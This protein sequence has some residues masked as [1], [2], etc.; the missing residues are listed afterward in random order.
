MLACR[1]RA[2]ID[3]RYSPSVD[4]VLALAPPVLRHRMAVSFAGRAEG[5]TVGAG[6]RP[7]FGAA[8]V[9]TGGPR[10][11]AALL[12][13]RRAPHRRRRCAAAPKQAAAALPPLLVAAERVAA[14]VAQGVHGR[15]RVGPGRD[16][17]AVPPISAGRRGQPH[18]LARERQVAAPLCPR[19]RMGGG[20]ERVAVARRLGLDGLQL[21]RIYCRRR[22]ADQARP[23]R[24]AAGRAGEPAG[25]RRRARDAA[26]QRHGAGER[27]GRLVAG[28][29]A[30]RPRADGGRRACPPSSRCRAP[31]SSC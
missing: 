5:V 27:P 2:L 14:T 22:L 15:R 30:A 21:G 25:A 19:D 4:D 20:A 16:L 13:R 1:A 24:I 3:G 8:P 9:N 11:L 23:R 17:L 12:A 31:A 6:H 28:R 26:R 29:R 7:D 18:R 10:S